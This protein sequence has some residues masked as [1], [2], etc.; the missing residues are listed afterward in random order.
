MRSMNLQS[1]RAEIREAVEHLPLGSTLILLSVNWTDYE[2]LLADLA[3][4][5]GVRI[6]Y[7]CGTLEIVS[8]SQRHENRVRFLE[9]LVRAFAHARKL[10]LEKF[11]HTTWKR[12]SL[13]KG[14]EPDACYYVENAI[15]IIGKTEIDLESS[16]PPD[17]AVE[18]DVTSDSAKKLSLYAALAIPEVWLDDGKRFAIY[19][20]AGAEY[21]EVAASRFLSGLSGAILTKYLDLGAAQGQTKALDAFVRT[22][23]SRRTV[24]G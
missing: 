1:V 17:I 8:P 12:P 18:I 9:D 23:K 19:E 3:H 11:G 10:P 20:L 14:V 22:I 7:D 21:V 13:A 16:P 6:S 5:S 4:R 15:Q 2:R 24:R